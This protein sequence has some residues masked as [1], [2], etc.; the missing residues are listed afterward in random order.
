M[1]RCLGKPSLVGVDEDD[2]LTPT[3]LFVMSWLGLGLE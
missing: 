3:P 2:L 1:R